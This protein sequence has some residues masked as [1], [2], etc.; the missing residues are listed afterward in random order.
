MK[1]QNPILYCCYNRLENIEKS[2]SILTDITNTRIYIV[3]DGPKNN[4]E[5]KIKCQKI[6]NR[7]KEFKFKSKVKY[8]F[9][10]KNLGCKLSIARGIDWFFTSEEKG[11]I[12][13]DD[14][15][16]SNSF[17]KFC[18]Y[19]LKEY[20]NEKSVMMISGTNYLGENI[21]SNK[22]NYSEHF[23][24]W[25]WATWKRA[26][27]YYDIEMKGW[28]DSKEK[29]KIKKRFNK[30]EF[31]FLEKKFNSYFDIYSDTWDIQW[32]FTCIKYSGIT[33]MPEA[34]LVCNIGQQGT[35]SNSYYKTLFMNYGKIDIKKIRKPDYL[36]VNKK[37]DLQIHKKFNFQN[38][39]INKIKIII[40]NLLIFLPKS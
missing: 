12:L 22:Y 21:I 23:L 20:Q 14:I 34:N 29:Q 4:E 2:L 11:I 35:H 1:V 7:I 36:I 27:K 33:I 37:L 26:W 24:I 8:Y 5:D 6:Q 15:I 3:M 18:D 30:K 16:V 32:Y 25:G 19:G 31:H 10:E 39:F 17:F 28:E 40:K 13:E 38:F 9:R